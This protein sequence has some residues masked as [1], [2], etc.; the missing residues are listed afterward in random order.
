[1]TRTPDYAYRVK[2]APRPFFETPVAQVQLDGAE[3]L[4]ADLAAAVRDRRASHPGLSRSNHLGW[5]SDTGMLDW[6]G[7][8]ARRLSE[9][10]V[11]VA[12]RMSH[13]KEAG[14]DDFDWTVA[15]W[16][17]VSPAGALNQLHAHPGNL[18]AAVFYLDLGAE[19]GESAGGELYLEDP[20]FPMAAM[21]NTAF[22]LV[23]VDG[24]PQDYQP[25][26]ALERGAMVVFP[27][28]LRHGVRPFHGSHDRISV[29]MNI[30][31]SRRA[32]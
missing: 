11:Q 17:N 25:N 27:A 10:A 26:L 18:W 30:D 6:G 29:A 4:M 31:A 5:H 20:R 12:K 1:M 19:P 24:R 8:A 9:T 13:F 22:R 28:W 7:A 14:V 21:R 3:T 32:P 15:M 23:G 16:A 2:A